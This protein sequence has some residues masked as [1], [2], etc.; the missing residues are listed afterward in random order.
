[1]PIKKYT[2]LRV[3]ILILTSVLVF[4]GLDFSLAKEASLAKKEER[5]SLDL[6]GID[7]IELLRIFSLKTG[8][9][10]VPSKGTSGRLNIFLNNLTFQ[11]ALD[12]I[13]LSQDLACEKQGNVFYIMTQAEYK[14]LYG[15]PYNEKR[16]FRSLK[17]KYAKPSGVFAAV[18]QLKSDI[19]KIIIDESTGTVFLIDIPEKI[20]LME[21]SIKELDKPMELEIFDLNY[22]KTQDV[23]TQLSAMATPGVGQVVV[24]ERSSKA[25]VTDLPEKMTQIKEV[26]KALDEESRQ[27]FIEGEI[28]QVILSDKF[29]RG[30]DWTKVFSS[31]TLDGLTFI[32]KYPL[33][34]IPA[35]YQSLTVGSLTQNKYTVVL[36]VLES[37]GDIKLLSR[38]R[39]AA[40]NNQEA[41][42]MVG[43]RD[44]YVT[45]TQS[46]SEGGVNVVSENIEFID[47]GVKLNVIPTIN[48]EGFVTMKI[49]AEVSSAAEPIIT[50]IGSR[51]PIVE[52]SEAET[53]VKVKD[54]TMIMIG[55]LIK[56]EKRDEIIG[57]PVLAKIPILG[58][59]F[60][61]RTALTKKTELIIFLTPHIISGEVTLAG[62]EPKKIFPPD[63]IPDEMINKIISEKVEE[64]EVHPEKDKLPELEEL[65]TEQLPLEKEST[66]KNIQ[67]KTKKIKEY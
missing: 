35:A 28:L 24:D 12:V 27:V 38:P 19:G 10:I 37:Y 43:L 31:R 29:Q 52:T 1:M 25:V 46:T 34:P 4:N 44:A 60:G 50:T 30:I 7:I 9:T 5:I 26:V 67:E 17:L 33:S 2:Y 21:K 40:V 41:K 11:D 53:T 57:L 55:G 18:S 20:E 54:G 36:Q 64:I 48:K 49:K 65:D 3:A 39:I 8:L 56:D 6:K 58:A 32:G 62:T 23:K 59:L 51:I 15:K 63:I 14:N 47:V 45:S 42:V 66:E 16:K 61:T 22:A 13:L